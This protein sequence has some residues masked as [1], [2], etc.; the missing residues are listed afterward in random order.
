LAALSLSLIVATPQPARAQS[1]GDRRGDYLD[2]VRNMNDIAAQKIETEVR[3]TLRATQRLVFSDPAKALE[4]LKQTLAMLQ[5]DTVLSEGRRATLIRVVKDRIRVA[6]AGPDTS[7]PGD[8]R[9]AQVA[10]RQAEQAQDKAGGQSV[11][12]SLENIR[13]LQQDGKTAEASRQA[14]EL[15]R[16]NPDNP[17]A[18]AA[19]RQAAALDRMAGDR[20]TRRQQQDRFASTMTDIDRSAIPPAG[21]VDFPKDWKERSERRKKYRGVQLTTKEKAILQALA[22][23]VSV[24]FQGST[25]ETAIDYLSTLSNQPIIVDKAALKDADIGYDS[26]VNFKLKNVSMRTVLR[27]LLGEFG[28]AYV[29]KDQAIL[30]T[31]AQRAKEMMVVRAYPIGDLVSVVGGIGGLNPLQFGPVLGQALNQ[32]QMTQNVNGIISMI[33]SSVEPDSWKVNGGG[34]TIAYDP[35]TMSLLVKQS[36]EVHA[37]M[38]G[39][40][41]R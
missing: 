26:P 10:S 32:Q 33:Q 3:S 41:G 16:N 5:D 9:K 23:P 1:T 25:F 19:S 38:G 30:I 28:L 24:N 20:G 7:T 37:L 29:V 27:K 35:L 15:A 2:Q 18:Q 22:A 4:R 34:G 17:A 13:K 14:A 21:D 40:F 11:Q 39:G 8:S 12:K 31:T 36:A 6:Q